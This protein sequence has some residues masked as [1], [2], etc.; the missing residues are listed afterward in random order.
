[1]PVGFEVPGTKLTKAE[2]D[3]LKVMYT[4]TAQTVTGIKTFAAGFLPILTGRPTG[5][6]QAANKAYVDQPFLVIMPTDNLEALIDA[7]ADDTAFWLAPGAHVLSGEIDLASD[8][9]T[10]WGHRAAVVQYAANRAFNITGEEPNLRGF[11]IQATNAACSHAVELAATADKAILEML[12]IL[13]IAGMAGDGVNW[14]NL[15]N[16]DV[17]R[18]VVNG[19]N[20]GLVGAT[21]KYVSLA[22]NIIQESLAESIHIGAGGDYTEVRN[23]RLYNSTAANALL[24]V[25]ANRCKV[26]GNDVDASGGISA[27]AVDI[28][29][30]RNA[31]EYNNIQR[32]AG[33]TSIRVSGNR[34]RLANNGYEAGTRVNTGANNWFL[35][36]RTWW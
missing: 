5:G 33:N 21:A 13:G 28:A 22:G 6:T 36:S 32:S 12:T 14:G 29:G 27:R 4:D 9:V 23:N 2:L 10:I 11:T 3:L 30:D 15:S 1:M 17:L 18:C 16:L 19:T 25:D 8:R 34:N 31:L 20:R 24:L 35:H 7:A 26:V